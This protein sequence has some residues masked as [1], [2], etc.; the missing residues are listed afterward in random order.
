MKISTKKA[1]SIEI[2]TYIEL[3]EILKDSGF[4]I[5]PNEEIVGYEANECSFKV[6][7]ADSEK[8]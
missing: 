2:F 6:F 3:A 1:T 5:L 4:R 8:Q 7:L